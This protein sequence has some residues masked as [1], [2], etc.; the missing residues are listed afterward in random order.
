MIHKFSYL[1]VHT[2]RLLWQKRCS[3][4]SKHQALSVVL[5]LPL[6]SLTQCT[7]WSIFLQFKLLTFSISF[8]KFYCFILD[9]SSSFL[10]T[11]CCVFHLVCLPCSNVHPQQF[12]QQSSF[13]NLYIS[14]TQHFQ[15]SKQLSSRTFLLSWFCYYV[16]DFKAL[17]LI[18]NL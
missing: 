2:A 7:Q 8:F 4:T 16:C 9:S 17:F 14:L 15:M 6:P 13:C 3:Q 18:P 12:L 10:L 11:F 5:W 1:A